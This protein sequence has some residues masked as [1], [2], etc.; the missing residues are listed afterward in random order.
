MFKNWV[1]PRLQF[2]NLMPEFKMATWAA[3][4]WPCGVCRAENNPQHSG[5]LLWIVVKFAVGDGENLTGKMH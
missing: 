1:K 2:R 4:D 3:S 5:Q